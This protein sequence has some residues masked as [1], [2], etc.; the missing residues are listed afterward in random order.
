MKKFVLV[1]SILILAVGHSFSQSSETLTNSTILKM[2]KA[3]LSDEIIIDEINNGTVNFNLS[4]DS[5]DLLVKQNV[6][7]SVIA[8][9][10]TA[11]KEIMETPVSESQNTVE[12]PVTETSQVDIQLPSPLTIKEESWTDE[13]PDPE[14]RNYV[15]Q[16]SGTQ[17]NSISYVNHLNDLVL[18]YDQQ[19]IS[20]LKI[21][22]KWDMHVAQQI[23]K[24][25]DLS[26]K[27]NKL[28]NDLNEEKNATAQPFNSKISNLKASLAKVR[29]EHNLL[30]EKFTS[31]G[32]FLSQ[33]LTNLDKTTESQIKEKFDEVT[34]KIS[35]DDPDPSVSESFELIEIPRKK[36]KADLVVHLTPVTIIPAFFENEILQVRDTIEIWSGRAFNLI[37]K[38]ATV[39]AKLDPL[40][41]KLAGY[42]SESKEKQKLNKLDIN[43]LKKECATLT[44]ERKNLAK[45][46]EKESEQLADNISTLKEQIIAAINERFLDAIENLNQTYQDKF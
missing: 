5:L 31:Y 17:V 43:A 41:K 29:T 37:K 25:K 45:Q 30:R 46:M 21:I 4:S 10:K 26:D 12:T 16:R 39:K 35:K 22:Q 33:E 2:V 32:K 7:S 23:Q 6:S 11:G 38:D 19:F 15:V 44:K 9:M 13:I 27:M 1:L 20:L 36:F 42:L 28:R 18:F 24:E 3:N 8:A 34:K 40:T 14:N